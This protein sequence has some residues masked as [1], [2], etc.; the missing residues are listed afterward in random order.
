MSVCEVAIY[1][2]S[3]TVAVANS[4][5]SIVALKSSLD[6][7]MDSMLASDPPILKQIEKLGKSMATTLDPVRQFTSLLSQSVAP[8][9]GLPFALGSVRKMC[10]NSVKGT[11][12]MTMVLTKPR[13]LRFKFLL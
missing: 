7:D 2:Y 5:D 9:K 6:F 11:G 3:I 1:R 4:A 12:K 8:Y 10:L 13:P